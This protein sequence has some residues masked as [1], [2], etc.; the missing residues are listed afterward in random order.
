MKNNP[1]NWVIEDLM[2]VAAHFGF[3]FRQPGTSH[4]TF[5]NGTFRLTIPSHKR[6]KPIYVKMFV[7]MIEELLLEKS[8]D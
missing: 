3:K 1:N 2:F 6:I 5:Y 4:V 8:Y 7:A